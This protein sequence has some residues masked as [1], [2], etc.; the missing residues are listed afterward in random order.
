MVRVTRNEA[1]RLITSLSEQLRSREPNGGREEF[2]TDKG[3][4]FSISV[5]DY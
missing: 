3:E 1:L 5:I 2:Q 4:Y